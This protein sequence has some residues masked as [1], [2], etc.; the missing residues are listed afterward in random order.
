MLSLIYFI[1]VLSVLIFAHEFGHFL[2]ARSVGV[3]VEI[4]SFG[5]GPKLFSFRR[6]DTEYAIS[7]VPLGGYVKMAGDDP[8]EGLTHQSWEF[9]SKTIGERFRVIIAGPLF[10]YILAFIIFSTIFMY[11]NPTLTTEIGSLLKGY[12]AEGAGLMVGD[13]I[14]AI[15]GVKVKYWED[16]TEIIRG[17]VDGPLLISLERAGAPLEIK[18]V[19]QIKETKDL[20]GKPVKIALIGIAPSQR[21]EKVRY[22]F[23]QAIGLGFNKLIGI[24]VLTYKALFAIMTGQLSFKESM[25]GPIG[26]FIITGK[27]AELG[28]IYIFHLMALLSASLAIFNVLPF[29][30]LDGGHIIFLALEKIRKKPLSAKA[31]EQVSNAGI[32]F[33]ITLTVF[34][35]YSDIIKFGIF[36]KV[37]H[38]FKK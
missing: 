13:T 2:A 28:I 26:I 32:A 27:A 36:E 16:A 8:A 24:T 21:I 31:Q 4:F 9:L 29:P 3:R 23:F 12:P 20:F 5:F 11:G 34:V 25:T 14:V 38:I 6:G 17:R 22:G 10:N 30:V 37:V 15:D 19:P 1:G 18:V 35:F 7:L 33:L